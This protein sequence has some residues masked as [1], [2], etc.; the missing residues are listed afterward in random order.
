ME[1]EPYYMKFRLGT[2]Y[3]TFESVPNRKQY[4]EGSPTSL[5]TQVT[6]PLQQG[7]DENPPKKKQALALR[8]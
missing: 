6:K 3:E 1:N 8:S 7:W 4:F 5:T 2:I